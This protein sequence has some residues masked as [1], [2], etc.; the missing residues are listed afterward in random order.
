[1][2][3]SK[4]GL[5]DVL[6][7]GYPF[8]ALGAIQP[9]Y[10]HRTVVDPD[11]GAVPNCKVTIVSETNHGA[12]LALTNSSGKYTVA[13]LPADTYTVTFEARRASKE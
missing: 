3:L 8:A 2:V 1:L 13:S 10:D 5:W 6:T 4:G 11:N 12:R 7:A 9:Q